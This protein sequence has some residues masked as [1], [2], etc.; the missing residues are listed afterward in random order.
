[1]QRGEVRWYKFPRP[2][3][4][5]PVLILTRDSAIPYLN[6]IVVAAVTSSIR[7]IPSEVL[8]TTAD[9]L[10]HD[11]VVNLDHINTVPKGKIGPLI[12]TLSSRRMHEV[13]SAIRF[14][15]QFSSGT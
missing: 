3:K 10:P 13:E 9:G 12:A 11:S 8:V 4:R 6:E 5:R 2:N 7:D 14:T 1:M 15:L